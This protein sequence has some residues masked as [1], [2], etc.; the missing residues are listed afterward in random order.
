LTYYI[1]GIGFPILENGETV[2]PEKEQLLADIGHAIEEVAYKKEVAKVK[3]LS[4]YN[5]EK[6][7][8]ILYLYSTGVSQTAMVRKHG[9]DRETVINTLV[10]YADHKG[11]FR[12]LG[13]KLSGRNYVNLSS[14][15]E[16]LVESL[17]H[18]LEIGDIEASFRDLKDLSIA[19][20]NAHREASTSRGDATVIT[21]E[22]KVT[23]IED[24]KALREQALSRIKDAEV[25]DIDE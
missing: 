7:A 24:A 1:Y 17:R 9:I 14:L 2:N 5:P 20:T 12:E 23:T 3:S 10:E 6:V 16:D 22:R 19:L 21:E 4:R 15:T 25:I 11:K 18:R 13:G 8:K